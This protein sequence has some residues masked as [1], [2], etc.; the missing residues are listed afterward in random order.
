MA[1]LS[2]IKDKT[3][4]SLFII[5]RG[6]GKVDSLGSAFPWSRSPEGHE[7]WRQVKVNPSVSFGSIMHLLPNG[8]KPKVDKEG[9][10]P[11]KSL[12]RKVKTGMKYKAV[13]IYGNKFSG[14]IRIDTSGNILLYNK[15]GIGIRRYDVKGYTVA[16][17]VGKG[18][19]YNLKT[20]GVAEIEIMYD[21][22]ETPVKPE[23]K[24]K[25]L[26]KVKPEPSKVFIPITSLKGI[27]SGTKFT[28]KIEQ[29]KV[30]GKIQFEDGRYFL[31][32]NKKNG[33][34]CKNKLDYRYSWVV[35]SGTSSE[36]KIHDVFN[37]QIEAPVVSKVEAPTVYKDLQV[38]FCE[39]HVIINGVKI[40][41]EQLQGIAITQGLFELVD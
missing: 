3:I 9:Y 6:S 23:P 36:L 18:S 20:N 16:R 22:P 34:D 15:S 32:Q 35:D 12:Y 2:E 33:S 28:A 1:Q 26:P 8:Y 14:V 4:K 29:T 27:K 40:T 25:P 13:T 21:I 24:P 17:N 41:D 19:V 5:N 38:N 30:T 11:V 7:F 31:C 10:T 37:L 39:D